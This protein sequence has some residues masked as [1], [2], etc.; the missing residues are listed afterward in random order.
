VDLVHYGLVVRLAL[1]KRVPEVN[2]FCAVAHWRGEGAVGVHVPPLVLTPPQAVGG[3]INE[4][5][6]RAGQ[7]HAVLALPGSHGRTALASAARKQ[8]VT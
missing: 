6:E 4:E 2:A 8:G 5:N 7:E 1:Q 3:D